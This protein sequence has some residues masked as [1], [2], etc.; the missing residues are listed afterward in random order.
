MLHVS[1][2]DGYGTPELITPLGIARGQGDR[3][4]LALNRRIADG[5]RARLRPPAG[6]DEP[7][8]QRLQRVRPQRPLAR[9]EP[10]DRRVPQRLAALRAD[11]PRRPRRTTIDAKLRRAGPAAR[12][13]AARGTLPRPQLALMWVPQT[14]GSPADRRQRAARAYWPGG[15]LRR[16]GRHRL[17]L[18]LPRPSTSSS[19]STTTFQRQAVRVRRVGA[20]GPRRPGLRASASSAGS[21]PHPRVQMQLYNQ[22]NADQRPVPPQPLPA[23]AAAYSATA[24]RDRAP[25]RAAVELGPSASQQRHEAGA[26]RPSGPAD[27]QPLEPA[28]RGT[29][30]CAASGSASRN[31]REPPD[32][33][34][35]HH[36]SA[37][38]YVRSTCVLLDRDVAE[39]RVSERLAQAAAR[40]QKRPTQAAPPSRAARAAP[41]RPPRPSARPP[42]ASASSTQVRPTPRRRSSRSAAAP[43]A[44]PPAR[45]R[46]R[47]SP[48]SV[49]AHS[50]A[51][52]CSSSKS[53]DGAVHHLGAHLLEPA[54]RR[55][56]RARDHPL[57]RGRSRPPRR[58]AR[59]A[60]RPA[61]ARRRRRSRRRAPARPGRAAPAPRA[62]RRTARGGRRRR[63]R[64]SARPA[65]RTPA[66]CAWTSITP[67]TLDRGSARGPR[68]SR[69]AILSAIAG[70]AISS[71]FSAFCSPERDRLNRPRKVVSSAT[72]TFACMKSWTVP[73]AYGVD[74]FPLNRAPSSTA[75]QDRPLPDRGRVLS[76]L[77][78]H[79]APAASS[80]RLPERRGAP[81]RRP[82]RSVPSRA[83][84]EHRRGDPHA[85]TRDADQHRLS[86]AT[87]PGRGP[88]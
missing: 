68:R 11:P 29:C 51:S 13:R 84:R 31:A 69:P 74:P 30:S 34:H 38:G 85:A 50:T 70:S 64:R 80:R 65:R 59:P 87:T 3:Y 15:A 1:T 20:V 79:L 18:A 22:G 75:R 37:L 57:G 78:E 19:A 10:L 60:A 72:V 12:S 40:R 73:G 27:S 81:R 88:E 76:P 49:N 45:P 26:C 6:R 47:G 52:K 46:R 2:Q 7:G 39:A 66:R 54:S 56:A 86:A 36:A 53:S 71:T 14:E 48:P 35:S 5:R 25:P 62:A 63:G 42:T 55:L 41:G 67:R 16:L 9:P 44:S 8:Q 58:S 24:L 77:V 28:R 23:L 33:V 83:G 17:L 82:Q 43:A 61:A 32:H 21:P 4:L